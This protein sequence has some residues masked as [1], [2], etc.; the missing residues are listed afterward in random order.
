V[1]DFVIV[2]GGVGGS[3]LATVVAR[4]GLDVLVLERTTRY[5]DRVRGEWIAPWGVAELQALGLYEELLAA[6]AHH[7]HRH[8]S[9]DETISP[10]AAEARAL[11]LGVFRAGIPG[12][13][14]IGHPHLCQT[15]AD[16]AR[17]SGARVERGVERVRVSAGPAP[18]VSYVREGETYTERCRWI[19]GADGRGSTVR[20]QLGIELCEDPPH[21]L[22]TGLLVDD[23]QGWPEDLQAI[24]TEGDFAFLAFPQGKGRVRLYGGF[25][26][27][28]KGRFA[29]SAGP[30]RFLESFALDCCPAS[31]H[32]SR[33]RPAGPCLSYP[34][35][36]T[37][38]REPF[39]P[40]AL[41]IG[42]A[43]GYNDP[44]VGQGLS[45]TL[46]DVRIVRD[47]LLESPDA[48]TEQ[49]APYAEE[50]LERMRRLRFA[51]SITST[52]DCEFD[53]RA[54]E[55]RARYLQRV[56]SE[57]ALAVVLAAVLAGPEQL[58]AEIFSDEARARI[59]DG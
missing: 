20:R 27:E 24:G 11:P 32:L 35:Q 46:R 51:A 14:C 37:W 23:A 44:I 34:N 42:D 22:F 52:L 58:P 15:L 59:L 6:G 33:A 48:G 7:L 36:D 30:E 38:T 53:G 31:L 18:R 3:A 16:L 17:M 54:R 12:P 21:H 45:I 5:P 41:L 26:L 47:L 57:P 8:I 55:R 29:G 49:L 28:R 13:L 25:A 19:V 4:A 43:A 10:E 50:R 9:Y 39:V 2:G 56:A 1:S 40:G